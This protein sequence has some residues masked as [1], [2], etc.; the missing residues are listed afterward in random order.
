VRSSGALEKVNG[1][2]YRVTG[3]LVQR[4]GVWRWKGYH[5]SEPASWA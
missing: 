3:V 5:G 2:V 4:D 1:N